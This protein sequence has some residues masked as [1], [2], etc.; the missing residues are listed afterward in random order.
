MCHHPVLARGGYPAGGVPCWGDILPGGTLLG[1]YPAG[2]YPARGV[3]CWGEGGTLPGGYPAGGYPARGGGTLPGEGVSLPGGVPCW[4][5]GGTLPGGYPAGGYPVGGSIA[6]GYPAGGYL[7]RGV[8]CQGGCPTS[9][10]SK[11]QLSSSAE[12][13]PYIALCP[14][15]LWVMLQSI[16]GVLK[17]K[18]KKIMGW[19]PLPPWTGRLMDGQTRVKTLPSLVLRT[20]AVTRQSYCVN[21]R[22]YSI[23]CPG[24]W[25]YPL[26]GCRGYPV[27]VPSIL[28]WLGYP[29]HS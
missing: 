12:S 20:R 18:K 17:K 19:V 27:L 22:A 25:G 21:A 1:E 13:W 5:R 2:G 28:T 10:V 4:G 9:V 3:P 11:L 26:P 24:G 16:M 23:C 7:A 14:M 15:E 6:R 8:P 29:I